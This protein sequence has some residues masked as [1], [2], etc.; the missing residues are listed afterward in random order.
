[1]EIRFKGHS[2]VQTL[3]TRQFYGTDG[4]RLLELHFYPMRFSVFGWRETYISFLFFHDFTPWEITVSFY[5]GPFQW[6]ASITF[7]GREGQYGDVPI[8]SPFFFVRLRYW[9]VCFNVFSCD[10]GTAIDNGTHRIFWLDPRTTRHG[11]T[12]TI[13]HGETESQAFA[14][15][16]CM[17]YRSIPILT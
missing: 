15:F 16:S 17:S 1:M 8:V 9:K 11:P 4:R 6:F 12:W 13:L 14:F 5:L 10:I 7:R 2:M 3:Y